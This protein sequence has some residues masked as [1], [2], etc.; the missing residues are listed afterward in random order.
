M[1][2]I[3]LE[4]PSPYKF[5]RQPWRLCRLY[6]IKP[7]DLWL[8]SNA[9][10]ILKEIFTELPWQFWN[11]S[12]PTFRQTDYMPSFL[13]SYANEAYLADSRTWFRDTLQLLARQINFRSNWS[14]EWFG[15]RV[16]AATHTFHLILKKEG[17]NFQGLLQPVILCQPRLQEDCWV[18]Q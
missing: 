9:S 7:Y 2:G 18:C 16:S 1:V 12:L 14:Q 8:V 15:G 13:V 6:Q 11:L 4:Q 5:E 3:A 17:Q 10:I